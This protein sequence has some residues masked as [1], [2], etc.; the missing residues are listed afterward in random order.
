MQSSYGI[1]ISWE[2]NE[3]EKSIKLLEVGAVMK[4]RLLLHW[5]NLSSEAAA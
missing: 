3:E 1:K 5:A 2:G 4:I